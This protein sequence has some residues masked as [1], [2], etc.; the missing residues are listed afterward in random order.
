MSFKILFEPLN[1]EYAAHWSPFDSA[2]F[3]LEKQDLVKHS[4]KETPVEAC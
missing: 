4:H 3:C 2:H 1:A